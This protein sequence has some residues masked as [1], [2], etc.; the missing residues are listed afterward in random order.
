MLRVDVQPHLPQRP[1]VPSSSSVATRLRRGKEMG[2]AALVVGLGYAA[3]SAY[4]AVGGKALLDTVEGVFE[5]AGR[6]GGWVA[7][8]ALWLVVGIK[9]VAA[10]LPIGTVTWPPPGGWRRLLRI[11][12]WMDAIVLTLYGLVLTTGD[13]LSITGLVGSAV[14]KNMTALTWHGFVWDPWFLIWGLLGMA[15]LILAHEDST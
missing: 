2:V 3:I 11:L 6:S 5:Q 9:V 8:A 15:T 12:A 10:G 7:S 14:G 1:G 4:W 13:L